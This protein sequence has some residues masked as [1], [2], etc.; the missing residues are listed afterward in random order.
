MLDQSNPSPSAGLSGLPARAVGTSLLLAVLLPMISGRL[1]IVGLILLALAASALAFAE[2]AS[3]PRIQ[4]IGAVA[5]SFLALC[6]FAGLSALWAENPAQPLGAAVFSVAVIVVTVLIAR[7][8]GRASARV[9][10]HLIEGLLIGLLVGLAFLLIEYATSN[11]IKI[12]VINAI[13]LGP[14]D[15]KPEVYYVWS[16]GELIGITRNAMTRNTAMVSM[17]LWPALLGV[18]TAFKGRSRWVASAGLAC[19]SV[20]AIMVSP[21]ETSKLAVVVSAA[22]F[23]LA[24]LS[25]VWAR[26]VLMVMWVGACL[27]ILPA[28]LTLESMKLHETSKWFDT[29]AKSRVGIWSLTA[30]QALASPLIGVGARMTYILGP[31]F[32]EKAQEEDLVKNGLKRR[33]SRHAHNAFLQMWFELGAIGALLLSVVGV[34]LVEGIG[35]LRD[36]AQ[37]YACAT[38]ATCMVMAGLS[39]GMWQG[40]FI[41]LFATTVIG[42][43]VV[44]RGDER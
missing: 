31:E 1:T 8:F 30:E 40:W 14:G 10:G 20:L 7:T 22:I 18:M 25:M 28:I 26:M 4:P 12:A 23:A 15:I 19:L 39:Y 3:I 38:F 17:I 2:R 34:M 5:W 44:A 37:P 13:G 16:G 27:L 32:M 43:M 42:L 29:H 6:G 24:C 36:A 33:M 11:S 9:I 35:R 21:H 41:A